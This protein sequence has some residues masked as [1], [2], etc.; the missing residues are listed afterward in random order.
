MRAAVLKFAS[1]PSRSSIEPSSE[2]VVNDSD[3]VNDASLVF[4][5]GHVTE[6]GKVAGINRSAKVALALLLL[7]LRPSTL[8]VEVTNEAYQRDM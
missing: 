4:L 5:E 1:S 6:G 8:F 7:T 2:W 3:R